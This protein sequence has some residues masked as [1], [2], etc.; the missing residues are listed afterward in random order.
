MIEVDF[1]NGDLRKVNMAQSTLWS[2]SFFNTQMHNVNF[3]ETKMQCV[4]FY[5][6]VLQGAKFRESQMQFAHLYASDCRGAHFT[7]VNLQCA[8]LFLT[9][10]RGAALNGMRCQSADLFHCKFG[11]ATAIY[12]HNKF[13][14]LINNGIGQKSEINKFILYGSITNDQAEKIMKS[15]PNKE[16][17]DFRAQ[18]LP[19]IDKNLLPN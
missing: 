5:K 1:K 12:S 19:H 3:Y 4:R 16:V 13:E 18:I 7:A 17:D 10:F 14:T 2:S 6:T 9:D 11:G 15:I 8:Q